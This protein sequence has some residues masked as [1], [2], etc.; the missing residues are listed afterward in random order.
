MS[1]WTDVSN[2]ISNPIYCLRWRGAEPINTEELWVKAAT[3][4]IKEDQDRGAKFLRE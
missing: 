3:R 2:V 4:R 1:K